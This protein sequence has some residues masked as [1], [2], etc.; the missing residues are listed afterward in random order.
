MLVVEGA[1]KSVLIRGLSGETRQVSGT[2]RLTL[3][4]VGEAYVVR[5]LEAGQ[6][7]M[8]IDYSVR[9]GKATKMATVSVPVEHAATGR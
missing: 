1:G 9:S 5:S 8:D 7:G 2:S 6:I 3:V 4:R